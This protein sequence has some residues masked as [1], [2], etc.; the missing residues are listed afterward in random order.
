MI[1]TNETSGEY[2]WYEI[3]F[4][5]GSPGP[6]G[7]ISLSTPVR[8]SVPYSVKL[9]NPLSYPVTFMAQCNVPEVVLPG[10]IS[11]PPNSEVCTPCL[12]AYLTA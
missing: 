7:T 5:A 11:V 4:K 6:L 1:F 12:R 9:D 2:Q 8:Q 3:Q 10:Q